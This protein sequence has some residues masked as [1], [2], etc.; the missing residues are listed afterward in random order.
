MRTEIRSFEV[1]EIDS[2]LDAGGNYR[3]FN[4]AHARRYLQQMQEGLFPNPHP[5]SVVLDRGGARCI[6]GQHRLWAARE[7]FRL[8]RRKI[9]FLVCYVKESM[10]EA[11]SLTADTGKPRKFVDHLRHIGAENVTSLASVVRVAASI[12][13]DG[14]LSAGVFD[15]SAGASVAMLAAAYDKDREALNEA[16]HVGVV[17]ANAGNFGYAALIG[18]IA[19]LTAKKNKRGSATFFA[20]LADGVGLD[21]GSPIGWL[22]RYLNARKGEGARRTVLRRAVV[23]AHMIKAWNAW[24]SG[25]RPKLIK[26]AANGERPEMFPQIEA[27]DGGLF[28]GAE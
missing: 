7:F 12:P 22:R 5:A 15:N 20:R 4:E 19:Y 27:G 14:Q 16:T 3:R 11:I 9:Q 21:S 13:E 23:A 26:W 8:T 1:S 17:T 18:S 28:S 6:D 10:I 2:L 24:A 25:E